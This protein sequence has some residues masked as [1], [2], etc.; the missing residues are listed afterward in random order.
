MVELLKELFETAGRQYNH[1]EM[2][3]KALNEVEEA[4]MKHLSSQIEITLLYYKEGVSSTLYV[5][6][7]V[8]PVWPGLDLLLV[9]QTVGI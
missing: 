1:L 5:I 9:T 3:E 2:T 6:V 8:R 4:Q 7:P